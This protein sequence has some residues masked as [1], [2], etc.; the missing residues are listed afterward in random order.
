MEKDRRSR[1]WIVAVVIVGVIICLIVAALLYSYQRTRTFNT[2]PLVMI[3]NPLNRD[4]IE[5]GE[6]II[7]HATGR[8]QRGV[9]R[10]ELWVDNA[11]IATR[12]APNQSASPLTLTKSWFPTSEGT[13]LIVVRAITKDGVEGQSSVG[14]IAVNSGEVGGVVHTVTEGETLASIAEEFGTT[15]EEIEEMNPGTGLG[16]PAPGTDLEVPDTEPPAASDAGSAGDSIPEGEG[17]PP[18][19]GSESPGDAGSVVDEVSDWFGHPEEGLVGLQIEIISLASTSGHPD[20]LHCYV[21]FAGA[22]PLWYPDSDNDQSTDE[23]FGLV[24]ISPTGAELWDA[25]TYLSGPGTTPVIF[26]PEN[27]PLPFEV[28]CV[29]V[30]GGGTEALDM[31]QLSVSVENSAWNGTTHSVPANGVD[32]SVRFTYRVIP[33]GDHPRGVPMFLDPDMTSPTN[34]HIDDRRISL[35]WDYVP[36]ED[37]EPIDG[38]RIYLNGNLQW[39]EMADARESGLPYEWLVPPCDTTYTF[40]VT[41]F[42]FGFPDGPE[43]FPG[44]TMINTPAENCN[45]E[46]QINFLTLETF[47]LGGDGNHEDRD[48]DIGPPY[49]WF[50]A[51][52]RGV[53]FDTR[54]PISHAAEGGL[55]L[56]RGLTHNTIYD[57]SDM[58]ADPTWGFG[59]MPSITVDIP[60]GGT[61]Q[62][63]FNIMDQDTGRCDDSDDPGC[64]DLICEGMSTIF[65]D[66]STGALDHFQEGALDSENG[67]CRVHY[68]FGPT[69]GSP[70]G[71]GVE[72]AEPLP[73]IDVEEIMIDESTGLMQIHVRNT[74]TATW[75][76]RDLEVQLETRSGLPIRTIT[77]PEYV[78]EVGQRDVLEDPGL[79]LEAPFDGCIVIDPNDQVLEAYERSGMLVHSS[80]CPELPDLEIRDV[81]FDTT[82]GGQ[83]RVVARN[84][85]DGPVANRRIV[86]HVISADGTPMEIGAS[87]PHTIMAPG[88]ERI[89]VIE[90]VSETIREQMAQGYSVVINP[91]HIVPESNYDNNLFDVPAGKNLSVYWWGIWAPESFRDDAA[92]DLT[93]FVVSGGAMR[94]V[95]NWHIGQDVDWGSCFTDSY[96]IRL[97][98]Q[99]EY[100]SGRFMVYG[101]EHFLIRATASNPGTLWSD[102]TG[103][104]TYGPAVYWGSSPEFNY[105][106]RNPQDSAGKYQWILGST[107][108][109]SWEVAFHICREET[110]GE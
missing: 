78:L 45:R 99:S 74:G 108:S 49:G 11:L 105:E 83:L 104:A 69:F 59:R 33:V 48:G 93:A 38:F 21:G 80:V 40:G 67:R 9:K 17:A 27:E 24:R 32:G 61:F 47:D 85:G 35:R 20:A 82:A 55:D 7:I 19:A 22:P 73:W 76:W 97:F 16:D 3:H 102:M 39:V 70:V 91:E 15:P 94:Q 96:C 44:V 28:A 53:Y 6:G 98:P 13:H 88:Q 54:A 107:S 2:R 56:A 84:S 23:S 43:S 89:F 41:A 60:P 18:A 101:D 75:P 42:R 110:G 57:L 50:Y 4:E 10:L 103:S 62:F 1:L 106:C 64:D 81:S 109:N 26:W 8:S 90:R 34:V 52:D 37:E 36:D 12:D 95:V 30:G 68:S 58:A 79:L 65:E 29:G 77:F 100:A 92:Y 5:L 71:T 63:G 25:E 51:N 87:Y 14:V 46:I 66:N 86:F 31:G 72:G